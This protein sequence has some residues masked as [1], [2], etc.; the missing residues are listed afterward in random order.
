MVHNTVTQRQ[1]C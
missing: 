1:F